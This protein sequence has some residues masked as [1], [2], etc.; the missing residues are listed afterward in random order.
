MFVQ[1]KKKKM[2]D[3]LILLAVI[4]KR[5]NPHVVILGAAG[6]KMSYRFLAIFGTL[7]SSSQKQHIKVKYIIVMLCSF[8]LP[9]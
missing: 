2:N 8:F 1:A 6:Q 9:W 4:R 3:D 5:K 7:Q